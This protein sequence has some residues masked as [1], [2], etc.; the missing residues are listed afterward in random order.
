MFRRKPAELRREITERAE[1]QVTLE[2]GYD[3]KMNEV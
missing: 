1:A 2:R 3:S